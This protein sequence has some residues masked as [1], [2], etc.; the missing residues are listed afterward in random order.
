M[1]KVI[2]SSKSIINNRKPHL[3]TSY[4][5]EKYAETRVTF[6]SHVSAYFFIHYDNRKII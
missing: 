5:D 6:L 4:F 2:A 1:E 3:R